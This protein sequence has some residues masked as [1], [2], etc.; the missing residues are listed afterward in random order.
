MGGFSRSL[1]NFLLCAD[2]YPELDI[3]VLTIQKNEI[4]DY[5]E[6]PKR[7][8]YIAIDELEYSSPVKKGVNTKYLFNIQR[9]RNI[10]HVLTEKA[11]K[12]TGRPFPYKTAVK[13][14]SFSE[15][16]RAGRVITDFSFCKEFDVAISWEELFCNY[17]LVQK[18]PVK[19]KIG[20]IHPNYEEVGFSKA[21]DKKY[22]NELDRI[23][24]ISQSCYTTL[25]KYYPEYNN[26]IICLPNRMNLS[27]IEKLSYEYTPEMDEKV[28]NMVTVCR[29]SNHDKAIFR[30][31][32]LS[33]KLVKKG[34]VFKWYVIGDGSDYLEMINRIKKSNLSET[35]ICLGQYDNPYP[36][37][38][39]ANLYVQQSYVEGKPVS[40][41]EA[42]ILNTP[43]LITDYS[44]AHEQVEQGV[45]GFIC[46][47][48]EE[49]IME[50]L[51]C[52]L[53]DQSVLKRIQNNLQRTDKSK[54][55]DCSSIIEEFRKV[56]DM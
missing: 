22:L 25:L 37:I 36:Y 54:Y 5:K 48:S 15:A 4:E 27:R 7:F 31:V 44:S 12:I 30:I 47:N 9:L 11:C 14:M 6:I 42:L 41:D 28:F 32:D 2:K 21:A 23:V 53:S 10:E 49:A 3:T 40:V 46:R 24:T 19:H 35:V 18:I 52:L 51:V 56:C 20:Y 34:F 55:E 1:I 50:Q 39:K 38:K 26:K 13:F 45:T 29:M 16:E 33:E 17:L 8:Q 43:V